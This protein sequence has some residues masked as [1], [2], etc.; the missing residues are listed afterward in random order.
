MRFRWLKIVSILVSILPKE[1]S[2][3][4]ILFNDP[5]SSPL[6]SI[7]FQSIIFL[8]DFSDRGYNSVLN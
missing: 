8:G 3:C 1:S 6:E 4:R 5:E 2:L 7:T